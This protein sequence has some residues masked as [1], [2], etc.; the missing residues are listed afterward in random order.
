MKTERL[1]I[2]NF[3][4]QDWRA[5]KEITSDFGRS[6]YAV[7]DMPFPKDDE[8]IKDMAKIYAET[9]LFFSVRLGEAMIGYVCFH[10]L[11][12]DYDIGYIFHSAYHGKGY[13]AEACTALMEHIAK[14][15]NAKVFTAG[16]ALANTPSRKL[17]E[18]LGFV[19]VGTE[20][21]S[22]YKDESGND[23]FFE[24]G[25]YRKEA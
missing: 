17:L 16:T 3:T 20:T 15:K 23:I 8:T 9:G 4:P 25:I 24:G 21:L 1:T 11:D 22:F 14:T 7:Y 6:E 12:G 10:E 2:K 19:L 5:L 18:K 13:A